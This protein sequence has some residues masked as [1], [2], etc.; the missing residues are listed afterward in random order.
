M[1]NA[2]FGRVR[3]CLVVL[4]ASLSLN[5]LAISAPSI[6]S[7]TRLSDTSVRIVWT[8]V[9]GAVQYKVGQ[10]HGGGTWYY[11]TTTATT[12]TDNSATPQAC[13]YYVIAIDSAGAS[14]QSSTAN[15]SASGSGSG[16]GGGSSGG[17]FS[18]SATKGTSTSGCTITWTAQSG[19]TGYRV[20]RGTTSNMDNANILVET[21]TGTSYTD[22]TGTAGKTYYYW[23]VAKKSSGY[24]TSSYATGYKA[25]SSSG[26]DSGGGSS[27]GGTTTTSVPYTVA[28]NANG[29][30]GTMANLSFAAG[31]TKALTINTFTRTGYIFVGWAKSASATTSA[32]DDGQSVKDLTTTSGATVTLYAV[33][34][35]N[36]YTIKFNKNGGS[37]TMANLAMKYGTAKA[38]TANA[39]QRPN[40]N[41]LGWATSASATTATY[42]NKQSVNNLVT[43]PDGSITLY[44]VW[45]TM[46]EVTAISARAR[47]PWNGYVD[48]DLT[49]RAAGLS[50]VSFEVKDTKGNTNLNARTFYLGNPEKKV[51]T[52]EA[53]PGT[54]RF[55]WDAA[56]D[57]GQV[58]IPSFA[59]TAKVREKYFDVNVTGGTGSGSFVQGKSA[60]LTAAAKTGYTFT[61][62]SGTDADKALLANAASATTTLTI[63][64]RDVA[65]EATY[66]PNTY[67]V[68]FNANAPTVSGTMSVESFTYD[69]AK[70]LTAN[71]F[72][73]NGFTFKG[74]AETSGATAAKY[75]D[76]QSVKNLVTAGT[77][78]LYA[79][80]EPQGVQ[81]WAGGPYWAKNNLGA[82]K[83]EGTGYYFMWG[84][85]VGYKRVGSSWNA[86][87]GSVTG[88]SFVAA[89]LPLPTTK[90]SEYQS[91][92]VIDSKCR[93]TSSYDAATTKL[94]SPWR[95][96]TSSDIFDLSHNT[97]GSCTT[98]NGVSGVLFTGKDAYASK[99]IFIPFAGRGDGTSLHTGYT[100]TAGGNLSLGW[101]SD[102]FQY[103]SS[104]FYG[105]YMYWMRNRKSGSDVELDISEWV[106]DR[107]EMST[108]YGLQIRPVISYGN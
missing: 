61:S 67:T 49:F 21:V 47:Y 53:Q 104:T 70:A 87:D 96:P 88:F 5:A 83:P 40:Y 65:Y 1:V 6:T 29:G 39:F 108:Y 31:A 60:T 95:M 93:L 42:T 35:A 28:F 24:V 82:T 80:W 36:A 57:L 37:G 51:T 103:S 10:Q 98:L 106:I 55:V 41:F 56:A 17:S 26:G 9:S 48:I 38:L 22:T 73:R 72:V 45:Q 91:A 99:S 94:G 43:T 62:W 66:T 100:R 14:A 3:N 32:Y 23:I 89:N 44:A 68:K 33:W 27:G 50:T 77:K 81:L 16:S 8:A 13:A 84:D 18:I 2:L 102:L 25:S 54:H 64:A 75:T 86:V 11:D 30:T 46:R 20:V 85:V 97:V 7:C 52:L 101:C 71:A 78:N 4:L 90:K 76:K 15:V 79:V 74:W 19:A 105:P 58:T 69:T 12:F 59:V 63:P 107:N 34:Q 92:G